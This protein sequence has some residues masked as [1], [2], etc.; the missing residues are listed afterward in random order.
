MIIFLSLLNTC[1]SALT[2]IHQGLWGL[3]SENFDEALSVQNGLLVEF[4]SPTCSHCKTFAPSYYE[5]AKQLKMLKN[6]NVG[7]VDGGNQEELL[8]KYKI[9]SFPTLIYFVNGIQVPFTGHRTVEGVLSWIVKRIESPYTLIETSKDL[10]KFSENKVATVYVGEKSHELIDVFHKAYTTLDYGVFGIWDNSEGLSQ[11]EDGK[12]I[13]IHYSD[14]QKFTYNLTDSFLDLSRFIESHKPPKIYPWTK[15][16]VGMILNDKYDSLVLLVDEAE[17]GAYNSTLVNLAEIYHEELLIT[18]TDLNDNS[19]ENFQEFLG[20]GSEKQPLAVIF[21]Y[22][23]NRNDLVKYK[24]DDLTYEGLE[25]FI[26]GW[27]N[28][29]LKP[30]YRSEPI[31]DLEFEK[32]IRVLVSDNFEK[33]VFSN[34]KNIAVYFYI[35]DDVDSMK[36]LEIFERAAFETKNITDVELGKINIKHNE[37]DGIKLAAVPTLKMFTKNKRL[38]YDYAHTHIGKFPIISFIKSYSKKTDL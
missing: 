5:A 24:T 3:T 22:K 36:G 6:L 18:N 14:K 20:F 13:V 9:K 34:D 21:S 1:Y 10:K 7:I 31:P 11:L 19:T 32:G 27:K 23:N 8:R 17:I 35:K 28:K 25:N 26:M 29:K 12:P 37:V 2:E 16:T 33:Y 4:F 30:Y 15:H 38:G